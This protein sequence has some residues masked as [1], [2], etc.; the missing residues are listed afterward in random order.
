[1]SQYTRSQMNW[2]QIVVES[3]PAKHIKIEQSV[4]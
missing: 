1:M 3:K 2:H 4:I